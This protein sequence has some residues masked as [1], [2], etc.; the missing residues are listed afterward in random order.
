MFYLMMYSAHIIYSYI[1]HGLVSA[2]AQG[3]QTRV[4]PRLEWPPSSKIFFIF[5]VT[6]IRNEGPENLISPHA[7]KA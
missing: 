7:F 5:L 4:G 3:P 1:T 2:P 6:N